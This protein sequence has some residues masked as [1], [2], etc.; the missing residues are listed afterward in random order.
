[1]MVLLEKYY[2]SKKENTDLNVYRCGIEE[3][4][5]NHSWGPGVRDHYIIHLIISG[6]GCFTVNGKT[7]NLEAG[8]GFLICPGEIV[9]YKADSILPWKYS[10]VGFHGLKARQ[11]LKRA[12]LSVDDPIFSYHERD[13]LVESLEEMI[14]EAGSRRPSD[15][16]LS[17]LLYQF[18][19]RLVKCLQSEEPVA[20]K[21]SDSSFYVSKAVEYIEKTYS[22]PLSVSGIANYLKIDR[23]YL[24]TLFSRHL[25]ISPREFI[26]NYRMNKACELLGN[27]QLSIGDV[28]RS[29][30]YEDPLQFSKTFKKEK[31]LSPSRYRTEILNKII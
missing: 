26:I 18:L 6:K 8:Q 19:A 16:M 13:L 3:C 17:G 23:S 10:W 22:G 25:G 28:A 11:I 27:P 15:L 31:G 29:V 14:T 4:L 2:I 7:H 21:N 20:G 30:G 12:G 1:M 9:S 5:P 24:S